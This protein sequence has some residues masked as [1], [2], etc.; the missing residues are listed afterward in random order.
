MTK[1]H[2][3]ITTKMKTES[4]NKSNS[5]ILLLTNTKTLKKA[6]LLFQIK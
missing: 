1:T 6:F 5:Q 3:K 2:N 4:K